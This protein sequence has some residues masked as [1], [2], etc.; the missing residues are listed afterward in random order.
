MGVGPHTTDK[1][2]TYL[3][4]NDL[5]GLP[6]NLTDFTAFFEQRKQR[7]RIRLLAALGEAPGSFTDGQV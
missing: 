6:R 2:A 4:E 7:A 3:A 5:E 1:R